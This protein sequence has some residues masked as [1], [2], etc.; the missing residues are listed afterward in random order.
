MKGHFFHRDDLEILLE[1]ALNKTLGEVDVN[2][3]FDKTKTKPK[4]TGI[5]GAVIEQS[6]LGLPADNK[7]WPDLDVDGVDTELK[8]TG[9]RLSKKDTNKYEAKEPLSIT[10]VS[11]EQIVSEV[12]STSNFWHKLEHILLV[13]Y[14]YASN[15]TVKA[16]QYSDFY[17]KGYEFYEFNE[18]DKARLKNDWEIVRDF[19]KK[20]QDSYEVPESQ[21]YRL[22]SELRDKLI[23]RYSSKVAEPTTIPSEE[24]SGYKYSTKSFW[25]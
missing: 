19:V 2:N 23:Y 13:Y 14:H 16:C 15:K 11:P 4:I 12:F 10:A 8:T 6:V 9:I 18:E 1:N 17:I 20:L 22:S 21:Y 24:T 3:V 5:A 25:R 7:Q